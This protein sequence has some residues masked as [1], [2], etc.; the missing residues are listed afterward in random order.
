MVISEH[1]CGRRHEMQAL[2]NMLL[3]TIAMALAAA[4]VVGY[5]PA[6]WIAKQLVTEGLREE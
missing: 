2:T 1:S 5:W 6:G 4:L 3:Q